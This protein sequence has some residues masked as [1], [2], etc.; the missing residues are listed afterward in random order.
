MQ[1]SCDGRVPDWPA[2]RRGSNELHTRL[3]YT[4]AK[5]IIGSRQSSGAC[6]PI[7]LSER[8]LIPLTAEREPH[9]TGRCAGRR[10]YQEGHQ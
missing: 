3:D 9:P 4:R 10:N 6:V 5:K 8:Q 1:V 7:S 2:L